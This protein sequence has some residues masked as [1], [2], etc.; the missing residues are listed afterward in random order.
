MDAGIATGMVW[1]L[2]N[3]KS[4]G[5]VPDTGLKV[6]ERKKIPMKRTTKFSV[7]N[8]QNRI[9]SHKLKTTEACDIPTLCHNQKQQLM[10]IKQD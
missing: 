1:P 3:C 6:G 5:K 10:E 2:G 8:T 4:T 7:I 9:E